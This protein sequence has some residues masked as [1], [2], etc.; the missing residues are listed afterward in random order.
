MPVA[1]M[2]VAPGPS[3][4]AL[5]RGAGRALVLTGIGLVGGGLVGGAFG[6]AAGVVLMGALRNLNRTRTT[7]SHPDPA[8]RSEAGKSATMGIFGLGVAAMLGY[9]AYK[10]QAG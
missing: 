7:W 9:Q 4:A 5:R 10:R 8:E 1:P 2:P 3:D 6:A